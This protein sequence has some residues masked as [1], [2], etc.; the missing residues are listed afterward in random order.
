MRHHFTPA[1]QRINDIRQRGGAQAPHRQP[2][3]P[4]RRVEG[5]QLC[6]ALARAEHLLQCLRRVRP[7]RG[8]EH[9]VFCM[10]GP[11]LQEQPAHQQVLIPARVTVLAPERTGKRVQHIVEG[12]VRV[13][14]A[15]DERIL[16]RAGL[17]QA[18]PPPFAVY[19]H[20]ERLV[21][22]G[23]A[24]AVLPVPFPFQYG[25]GIRLL[26]AHTDG[27]RPGA[28]RH[29]KKI[30]LHA[31]AAGTARRQRERKLPRRH[32]AQRERNKRGRVAGRK[33]QRTERSIEHHRLR[34]SAPFPVPAL[35]RYGTVPHRERGIL[36]PGNGDAVAHSIPGLRAKGTQA[37][38]ARHVGVRHA[39]AQAVAVC[40]RLVA[41]LTF[42]E[43]VG[44]KAVPRARLRVS[45]GSIVQR[46][47]A[48]RALR[49]NGQRPPRSR[50][51]Q[52]AEI[53]EHTIPWQLCPVVEPRAHAPRVFIQ[54]KKR[55]ARIQPVLG[56][57]LA[58]V[59][60]KRAVRRGLPRMIPTGKRGVGNGHRTVHAGGVND[61]VE[62]RARRLRPRND[63]GKAQI[64]FGIRPIQRDVRACFHHA[65]SPVW[66]SASAS[67]RM[68]MACPYVMGQTGISL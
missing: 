58:A 4:A 53:V 21:H 46:M 44:R 23:I 54:A 10:A 56:Q 22:T 66:Y 33:G 12:M 50:V 26:C 61:K 5:R 49:Q 63:F 35:R 7:G 38:K 32:R 25:P 52:R 68:A 13:G 3:A 16:Q 2:V 24:Q 14:Q 40:E 36:K 45:I 67:I 60:V 11:G 55:N 47:P 1:V 42:L 29:R 57:Q 15:G 8:R 17:Q 18:L 64:F 59:A 6:P 62:P 30:Q 41:E 34:R 48:D 39:V 19:A 65:S 37:R 9:G 28:G 51:F 20:T 27:S 31:R 43:R